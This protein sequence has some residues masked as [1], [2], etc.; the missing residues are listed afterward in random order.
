M[1]R[2]ARKFLGFWIMSGCQWR[3][4]RPIEISKPSERSTVRQIE[5]RVKYFLRCIFDPL[6]GAAPGC[7]ALT[8]LAYW[9]LTPVRATLLVWPRLESSNVTFSVARLVSI[10][11]AGTNSTLIWQFSPFFKVAPQPC[12]TT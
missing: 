11:A 12:D 3:L 6:S 2:L 4:V 9:R 7:R 1:L 8:Q 5:R 10:S